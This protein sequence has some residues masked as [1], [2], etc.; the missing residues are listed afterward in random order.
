VHRGLDVVQL[1][2]RFLDAA[3]LRNGGVLHNDADA[4]HVAA[5]HTPGDERT[6][7]VTYDERMAAAASSGRRRR[8]TLTA[9]ARPAVS[10]AGQGGSG[11]RAAFART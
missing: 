4:S 8:D 1:D 11:G 10:G 3:A 7:F 9:G 5:A 2:E 6:T